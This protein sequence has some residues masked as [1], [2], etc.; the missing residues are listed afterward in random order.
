MISSTRSTS[1]RTA[2]S[3]TRHSMS[4]RA[5]PEELPMSQPAVS[6]SRTQPYNVHYTQPLKSTLYGWFFKVTYGCKI[7]T[8]G[9]FKFWAMAD[10]VQTIEQTQTIEEQTI[11][12]QTIEEQTIEKQTIEKRLSIRRDF[13]ASRGTFP[14]RRKPWRF[15]SRHVSAPIPGCK[16]AAL[17]CLYTHACATPPRHRRRGR[18]T[19]TA[20]RNCKATR[21][22]R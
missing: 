22:K 3:S 10:A 4:S 5:S 13:R 20:W 21:I 15:E 6:S 14:I 8:A 19:C 9:V 18:R 2:R 7:H 17:F 12:K 16:R 1:R 11:K